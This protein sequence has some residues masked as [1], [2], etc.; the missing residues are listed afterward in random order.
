MVEVCATDRAHLRWGEERTQRIERWKE[1]RKG[2]Q[3][4]G[5]GER[6]RQGERQGGQIQA[7]VWEFGL[8]GDVIPMW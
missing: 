8:A 7:N 5:Q 3:G 2:R 4:E 1:G 6:R